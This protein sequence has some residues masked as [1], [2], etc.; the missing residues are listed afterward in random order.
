MMWPFRRRP[1]VRQE[2]G[3]YTAQVTAVLE[4]AAAGGPQ[5]RPDMLSVV[6]AAAALWGDA[7][8]A[9]EV[10]GPPAVSRAVLRRIGQDLMRKGSSTWVVGV[11]DAGRIVMERAVLAMRIGGGW[12]VTVNPD[13]ARTRTLTLLPEQVFHVTWETAGGDD[14]TGIPPW[15]N[16]AGELSAEMDAALKAETGGPMGFLLHQAVG[17]FGQQAAL[18]DQQK[19]LAGDGRAAP[20]PGAMRGAGNFTGRN[21]G[22]LVYMP[23]PEPEAG[24]FGDAGGQR[25]MRIGM[26]F[27]ES[28]A[29][30]REMLPKE[31]A[32][33]FGIPEQLLFGG[34][35]QAVREAWRLFGIRAGLRAREIADAL[36]E[37]LDEPVT[38]DASDLCRTDVATAARAFQALRRG[39]LAEADALRLAG[40]RT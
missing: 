9:M 30:M 13:P 32:A 38:L 2:A 31:V 17:K 26:A 39:D 36:S 10:T 21:R 27:P 4:A 3:D 33:A 7:L 16:L 19:E 11:D 40:L 18:D 34:P 1:Q 28:A 23:K 29:R 8:S 37:A 35:G 22:R 12:S 15:R 14:W 5:A 25:P 6:T 24:V 20:G